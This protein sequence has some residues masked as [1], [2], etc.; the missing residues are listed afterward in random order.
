MAI[1]GVLSDWQ[2]G[3]NGAASTLTDFS[4][5]T[6]SVEMEREA[7]Q[8]EATVFQST[9]RAY[10]ASFKNCNISATYKYDTTVYGQL[11]AIF[12][13]GTQ[14]DFQAS[15]TGTANGEVKI[16]GDMI[17]TGFNLSV[18]IGELLEIE[19]DWLATGTVTDSTHSA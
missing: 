18:G 9:Y 16:T 10:E 7:E 8:E 3:T 1:G 15:P 19:V 4:A 14:V 17:M 2:H 5:K 12:N 13:N 11:A 6:I